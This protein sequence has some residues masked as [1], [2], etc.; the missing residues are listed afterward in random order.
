MNIFT[1][2]QQISGV[3][4]QMFDIDFPL[5]LSI[6]LESLI[7][8]ERVP[9]LSLDPFQLVPGLTVPDIPR[10]IFLPYLWRPLAFGRFTSFVTNRASDAG[11]KNKMVEKV[12]SKKEIDGTQ[13]VDE[14]H[15]LCGWLVTL[16]TNGTVEPNSS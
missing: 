2:K 5:N 13:K 12:T 16:V 4:G 8:L 6:R 9:K 7:S 15:F 10:P 3:F 11:N 1:P 14:F